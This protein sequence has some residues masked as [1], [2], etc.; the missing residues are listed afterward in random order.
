M[1]GTARDGCA[2]RR[3]HVARSLSYVWVLWVAV[4]LASSQAHAQANETPPAGYQPVLDEAIKEF[5]VGNYVESLTLFRE[6]NEAWPNARAM[7]AIGRCQYE[8]GDYVASHHALLEALDMGVRP[9]DG[10]QRQ[11]TE[12]LLWR[13]REHLARYT[14][15]TD[16][17]SAS[18]RVDGEP[19][20]LEADGSIVLTLGVHTLEA[21]ATGFMAARQQVTAEA[22]R[23]EHIELRLAPLVARVAEPAEP[24]LASVP[25]ARSDRPTYKKWW[26]WTSVAG[27]VA[28]A[29]VATVLLVRRD[30]PEPA[31]PSGGSSGVAIGVP[32]SV[33][34]P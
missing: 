24:E 10:A 21:S 20:S 4:L 31:R 19:V 34:A 5:A 14:V 29:A 30:E 13:V 17:R 15:R 25:A 6:A 7:R 27:A 12:Q 2:W 22:L 11:E 26:V 1:Q 3:D 18:L 32:G 8:L 33:V 9:L 23:D 16:P 28:V